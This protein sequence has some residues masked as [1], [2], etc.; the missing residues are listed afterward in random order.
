MY[1]WFLG[2]IFLTVSGSSIAQKLT[3][4]QLIDMLDW[5]GKRIDT[6]LK[7]KDYILMHKDIDTTN[8]LYQYSMVDHEKEKETTVIR[9]FTYMDVSVQKTRSRLITYRTYDKEEFQEIASWLLTNSYQSTNQFDFGDEK[10][11]LFS[12]GKQSIRLKVIN[13]KSNRGRVFTAYE[14][15]IGR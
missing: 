6:T 12:N 7:K 9:S 4:P 1:K 2:L 11:T 14:L 8:A 15:E 3:V 5:T 13:K 10:H